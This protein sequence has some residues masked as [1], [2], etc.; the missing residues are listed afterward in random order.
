MF[1][2]PSHRCIYPGGVYL[3]VFLHMKLLEINSP[4]N[5]QRDLLGSGLTRCAWPCFVG[6]TSGDKCFR[7]PRSFYLR[8]FSRA[9]TFCCC[10]CCVYPE[11]LITENG[12]GENEVF[13]PGH[14]LSGLSL[15]HNIQKGKD[16]INSD[17]HFRRRIRR[18]KKPKT[19]GSSN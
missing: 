7:H 2:F 6:P 14:V 15:L 19:G 13:L 5:P 8:L 3:I 9:T 17:V 1:F 18:G 11:I 4:V 12:V 10:C 16:E